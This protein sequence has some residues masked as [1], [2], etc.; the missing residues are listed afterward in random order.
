MFRLLESFRFYKLRYYKTVQFLFTIVFL[1]NIFIYK[2]VYPFFLSFLQKSE[3]VADLQFLLSS[4]ST[5]KSF[6]YAFSLL[7]WPLFLFLFRHL[8][9]F[10]FLFDGRSA[11]FMQLKGKTSFKLFLLYLFYNVRYML[12]LIFVSFGLN[13]LLGLSEFSI[14]VLMILTFFSPYFYLLHRGSLYRTIRQN[15]LFLSKQS[16]LFFSILGGLLFF[17]L[18][19]LILETQLSFNKHHLL[20]NLLL[21]LLQTIVL[22]ANARFYALSYR[23]IGIVGLMLKEK[24]IMLF[25]KEIPSFVKREL[26][27]PL[28]RLLESC[29]NHQAFYQAVFDC[30]RTCIELDEMHPLS[31]ERKDILSK[32][33]NQDFVSLAKLFPEKAEFIQ[34]VRCQANILAARIFEQEDIPES[35][36]RYSIEQFLK[37]IPTLYLHSE[38]YHYY[39]ATMQEKLASQQTFQESSKDNFEENAEGITDIKLSAEKK[40]DTKEKTKENPTEGL[41]KVAENLNKKANTY[42][43]QEKM[44]EDAHK[45]EN[46][47]DKME[48]ETKSIR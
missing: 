44:Q 47:D 23:D 40:A 5:E 32:E 39:Q 30:T 18:S 28:E 21:I 16:Q 3:S 45:Q 36:Q 31:T 35:K 48:E 4:T 14:L 41:T 8:Y 9:V 34:E 43:S 37:Q 27:L 26:H 22:F 17:Y 10:L 15:I 12:L 33:T 38:A 2:E 6:A 13:A 29:Q 20:V 1:V 42:S 19:N 46:N 11:Y 24:D 25:V 7:L